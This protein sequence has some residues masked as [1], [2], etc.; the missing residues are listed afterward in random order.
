[1]AE[2]LPQHAEEVRPDW[3]VSWD[4]GYEAGKRAAARRWEKVAADLAE[5]LR[6]HEDRRINP[7]SRGGPALA[8]Y[9]ALID[10]GVSGE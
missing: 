7:T 5:A 10:G 6:F 3:S 4:E 2:N 8:R 9:D 1:M